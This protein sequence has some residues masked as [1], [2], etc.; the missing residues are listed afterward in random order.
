MREIDSHDCFP[1][2]SDSPSSRRCLGLIHFNWRLLRCLCRI[3]VFRFRSKWNTNIHLSESEGVSGECVHYYRWIGF[4]EVTWCL[5]LVYRGE[6]S[7]RTFDFSSTF[8]WSDHLLKNG[9]HYVKG[10]T[11][12]LSSRIEDLFY[13]ILRFVRV[14][15]FNLR[16]MFSSVKFSSNLLH[17]QFHSIMYLKIYY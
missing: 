2:A 5:E 12:H 6:C 1:I 15:W 17:H 4:V 11:L 10:I 7:D 14:C 13:W 3:K 9:I 16:F 8:P